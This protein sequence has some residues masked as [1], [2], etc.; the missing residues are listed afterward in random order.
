M[1]LSNKL[2]PTMLEKN[3][4]SIY[5]NFYID[6]FLAANEKFVLDQMD[7]NALI[8]FLLYAELDVPLG[9]KMKRSFGN[10]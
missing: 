10:I 5:L 4:E 2:D 6:L 9:N 3:T 8:L 7:G 1:D